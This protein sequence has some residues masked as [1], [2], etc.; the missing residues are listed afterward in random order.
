MLIRAHAFDGWDL[1]AFLRQERAGRLEPREQKLSDILYGRL[2][3]L[4]ALRGPNGFIEYTHLFI[5]RGHAN[6]LRQYRLSRV[7]E[8]RVDDTLVCLRTEVLLTA[9]RPFIILETGRTPHDTS[10]CW[11]NEE[12]SQPLRDLRGLLQELDAVAVAA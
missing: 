12:R 4:E 10:N 6:T 8:I 9:E 1:E 3:H 5:G 11:T 2:T 7:E